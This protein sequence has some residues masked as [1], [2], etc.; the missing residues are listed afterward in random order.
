MALRSLRKA[1]QGIDASKLAMGDPKKRKREDDG[2]GQET[3]QYGLQRPTNDE[4][5]DPYAAYP[6]LSLL[7]IYTY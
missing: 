1:K 7:L 6:L 2:E 4:D 3:V 5:N